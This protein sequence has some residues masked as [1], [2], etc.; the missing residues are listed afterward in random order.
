MS[1][2][3]L[4]AC[5]VAGFVLAATLLRATNV[6][7]TAILPFEHNS[8]GPA[9]LLPD[10]VLV[11]RA[12]DVIRARECTATGGGPAPPPPVLLTVATLT[13]HVIR[14]YG[15]YGASI[16]NGPARKAG[17]DQVI[18]D[19]GSSWGDP[20][21]CSIMRRDDFNLIASRTDREDVCQ[22]NDKESVNTSRGHMFPAAFL[23]R[24][25]GLDRHGMAAPPAERIPFVHMDVAGSAEDG[26]EPGLG[27]CGITGSPVCTLAGAFL[28]L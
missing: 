6:D 21:E 7:I 22:T 12:E 5:G 20:F 3:K 1:R 23:I 19:A 28:D 2:D 14:A 24:A 9:S 11:S 17:Y 25:T 8:V 15:W 18:A 13:G 27:L 16:A 10:E 26:V 4:G